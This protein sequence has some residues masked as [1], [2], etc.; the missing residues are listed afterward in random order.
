MLQMNTDLSNEQN[1]EVLSEANM[2]QNENTTSN[3]ILQ[4]STRK[5]RATKATIR[6]F[7]RWALET[8]AY[9]HYTA[10]RIRQMYNELFNIDISECCIRRQRNK[11]TL[12]D[13]ELQ[14]I[15]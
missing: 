6:T 14:H 4:R 1:N 12:I 15:E 13:G 3:I 11:W 7:L 5:Q 10:G 9:E 8:H 2:N